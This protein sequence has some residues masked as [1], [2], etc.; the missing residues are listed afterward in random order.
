MHPFINLGWFWFVLIYFWVLCQVLG[1]LPRS[2]SQALCSHHFC[3]SAYF[4]CM[5]CSQAGITATTPQ[6]VYLSR[7][8]PPRCLPTLGLGRHS[9]TLLQVFCPFLH[10]LLNS[11]CLM[12]L[13]TTLKQMN[14]HMH[15][16]DNED[17]FLQCAQNII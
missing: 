10:L 16:K 13:A 3:P 2:S 1:S 9:T 15:R 6:S 4:Y 5:L 11:L 7:L 17:K 14:R 8:Y 12:Q